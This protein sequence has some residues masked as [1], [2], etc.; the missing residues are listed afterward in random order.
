MLT[1]QIEYQLIVATKLLQTKFALKSINNK[2]KL[3]SLI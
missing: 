1:V 2:N 3:N